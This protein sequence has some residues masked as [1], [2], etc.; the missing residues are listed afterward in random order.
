MA[1][2]G[3]LRSRVDT[4]AKTPLTCCLRL[5]FLADCA[6]GSTGVFIAGETL[7]FFKLLEVRNTEEV[8]YRNAHISH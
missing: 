7:L 5:L 8:E 4:C 1:R 6:D 3:D 2:C